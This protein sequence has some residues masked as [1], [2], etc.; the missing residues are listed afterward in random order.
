MS[1]ADV[2]F[3]D[4]CLD[5]YDH[6]NIVWPRTTLHKKLS[7]ILIKMVVQ[8]IKYNSDLRSKF[9]SAHKAQEYRRLYLESAPGVLIPP[10]WI[11]TAK[12]DTETIDSYTLPLLTS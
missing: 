8:G 7:S 5:P 11:I 2:S 10:Y 9:Q 1:T 4:K 3:Q 12:V 6:I